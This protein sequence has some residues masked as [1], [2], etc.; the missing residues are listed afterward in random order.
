MTSYLCEK[1]SNP[2]DTYDLSAY[3]SGS[4]VHCMWQIE[5]APEEIV[6]HIVEFD[7]FDTIISLFHETL[8]KLCQYNGLYVLY[9]HDGYDWN[10]YEKRHVRGNAITYLSLCNSIR[11]RPTIRVPH[12]H[13]N[14]ITTY[15]VFTMFQRYSTGY[16]DIR[17][18]KSDCKGYHYEFHTCN[19]NGKGFR[20]GPHG[21]YYYEDKKLREWWGKSDD[22]VPSCKAIWIRNNLND[23]IFVHYCSIVQTFQ[24]LSDVF[25][26]GPQRIVINNWIIPITQSTKDTK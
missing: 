1:Y 19:T 23:Q 14:I 4:G 16:I 26:T 25:M 5:E 6:L 12:Y 18:R 7:G 17:Y 3:N 22:G 24:S 10:E 21:P 9:R 15:I 8:E 2:H 13:R 11:N 20:H